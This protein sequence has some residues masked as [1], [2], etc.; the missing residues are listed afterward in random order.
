MRKVSAATGIITTVVGTG[1]MGF[2][3][4]GGPGTAA[5]V[6]LPQG[7]AFDAA[8]NLFIADF[9]NHRIRMLA[10]DGT[11][12][13]VAGGGTGVD[14]GPAA[15]AILTFPESVTV[16]TLGNLYI[17]AQTQVRKVTAATGII[18]TVAGSG[19]WGIGGDGGPATAAQVSGANGVAVDRAGN[20][21]I[22]DGSNARVRKV[23]A[24]TGIITT[25][26]GSVYGFAGDGGPGTQARLG[27][28]YGVALDAAGNL[29]I[30]D[31][32]NGRIR[33]LTFWR[34]DVPLAGDID[35]DAR[36]NLVVWR[37]DTGTWHWLTSSSGY[38]RTF[39]GEKRWESGL[40]GD[41]PLLAD[42]DGDHRAELIVWHPATGTWRW[43]T[44]TSGYDP[45]Q[46]RAVPFGDQA[47]G[48]IPLP[49][50]VDGDGKADLVVWR[51]NTGTWYW[52]F[53]STGFTTVGAKSWGS[54]AMGDVPL[55]ADV[56]GD[57]ILD[58]TVWRRNTGWPWAST[59]V[60]FSLLSS[61]GYDSTRAI[62]RQWGSSILGDTPI[63]ADADGDGKADLI[64]WR[65]AELATW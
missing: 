25:V 13:T 51:A 1:V 50:D 41:V 17:A 48:D 12:T 59:G 23:T 40:D 24:A 54:K 33:K 14:G 34:D 64:V 2:S 3:G 27:T 38:D 49:G 31:A 28:T 53:S 22:S 47:L 44:S 8:G 29:F 30:S 6:S 43:L 35:G 65:P 52:L 7:L 15:G 11:V 57:G 32:E 55:Q 61:M 10:P 37:P 5:Q 58:P 16:D 42:L 18:T 45:A 9:G 62:A 39:A 20:L 4:D 36:A 56:D 46:A 26:A 60:W 21:Y 63:P 19:A